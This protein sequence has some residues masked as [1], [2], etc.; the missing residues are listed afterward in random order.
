MAAERQIQPRPWATAE[1]WEQHKVKITRMYQR[2]TLKEVMEYMERMHSFYA[3]SVS[4]PQ[5]SYVNRPLTV[6]RERMYKFRIRTWGLT[7]NWGDARV[8]QALDGLESGK[9]YQGGTPLRKLEHYLARK[10]SALQ[11]LQATHKSALQTLFAEAVSVSSGVSTGP[12]PLQ[13]R[14]ATLR[15]PTQL[16]LPDEI[17]RLL[18]TFLAS[19]NGGSAR[20]AC[21]APEQDERSR[22]RPHPLLIPAYRADRF[23]FPGQPLTSPNSA[24]ICP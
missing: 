4:F 9:P 22:L 8:Q 18:S 2:K 19:A 15:A 16:A 14:P 20:M 1:D 12:R 17:F 24:R 7:K 6:S 21:K 10:P 13:P 5:L 23:P 3:T 11:Q